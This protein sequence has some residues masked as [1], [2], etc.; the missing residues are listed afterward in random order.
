M[1][2]FPSISSSGRGFNYIYINIELYGRGSGSTY[3]VNEPGWMGAPTVEVFP[4]L[5]CFPNT[6]QI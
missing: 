6:A 5:P 2:T 1:G 4:H 3:V